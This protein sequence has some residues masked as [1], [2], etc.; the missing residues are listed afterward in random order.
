M[1]KAPHF[2]A[3]ILCAVT[4]VSLQYEHTPPHVLARLQAQAEAEALADALEDAKDA[5]VTVCLQ[6]GGCQ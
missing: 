1:F 3:A 2:I 4:Y 5:A 6:D